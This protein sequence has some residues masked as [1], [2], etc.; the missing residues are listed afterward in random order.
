MI[1]IVSL[2]SKF[3]GGGI[4]LRD[5]I[6]A[7]EAKSL[8]IDVI[9]PPQSKSHRFQRVLQGLW[10]LLWPL[11]LVTAP[12]QTVLVAHSLFLLSPFVFLLRKRNLFFLFQGEEYKA[13]HSSAVANSIQWLLKGRFKSFKCIT[14]NNYL[15]EVAKDMGGHPLPIK[16]SLGPKRVFFQ[17]QATDQRR[18]HVLIFAREGYNKGLDD[19][20]EVVRLIRH[21]LA[22]QFIAPDEA[23]AAKLRS[24]GFNCR[25]SVDSA[26]VCRE[27]RDAIALFLPSHYEGLSLPMLEALAAGAPVVT[28]SEG[29]PKYFSTFNSHVHFVKSRSAAVASEQLI[30]LSKNPIYCTG[31]TNLINSACFS[32]EDYCDEVASFLMLSVNAP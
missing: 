32:F 9:E 27:L 14:T 12:A 3:S 5:I 15:S 1:S 20:L 13:L 4:V 31:G 26:E 16:A 21:E 17:T 23:V 8:K 30:E 25:V 29:F 7:V 2:G 24:Q 6:A 22:V 18:R 19:A 10:I 28:Y 11:R